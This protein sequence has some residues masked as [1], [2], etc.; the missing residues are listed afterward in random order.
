LAVMNNVSLN[1]RVHICL[2][3]LISLF[4]LYTQQKDFWAQTNGKIFK[5]HRLEDEQL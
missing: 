1:I 5:V 3:V 2:Q 4:W